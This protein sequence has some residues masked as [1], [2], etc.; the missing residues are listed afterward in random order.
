[1]KTLKNM[2]IS[3]GSM[4]IGGM[5]ASPRMGSVKSIFGRVDTEAKKL[6]NML[7]LS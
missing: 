5:R 3:H 6:L 4:Y 7:L 1:M 2:K